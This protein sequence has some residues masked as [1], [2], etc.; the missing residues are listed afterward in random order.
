[1]QLQLVPF[2][3]FFQE[4]PNHTITPLRPNDQD[5]AMVG[6]CVP[7][8]CTDL[9]F[10]DENDCFVLPY[11]RNA[12]ARGWWWKGGSIKA[13]MTFD[14]S[15]ANLMKR[16]IGFVPEQL[17]FLAN[18]HHFWAERGEAPHEVGKHDVINLHYTKV[19]EAT[20]AK[21]RLDPVEYEAERGFM[22]YDGTQEVR[23]VV[24]E[25]YRT[26]LALQ[27]PE[28]KAAMQMLQAALAKL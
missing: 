10:V 6:Q 20:I 1:M 21:I 16:E 12:C 3:G 5:Y 7:I 2:L 17:T 26:Y 28:V 8:T 22:R 14:K 13:G 24:H 18:L 11:R 9:V 25:A 15:Y 4:D 19:D 27:N 23:P